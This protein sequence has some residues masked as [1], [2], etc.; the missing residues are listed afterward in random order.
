MVDFKKALEQARGRGLKIE[1]EYTYRCQRCNALEVTW[2]ALPDHMRVHYPSTR[3]RCGGRLQF[4]GSKP[5]QK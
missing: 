4:V 1:Y 5:S 2:F 3:S